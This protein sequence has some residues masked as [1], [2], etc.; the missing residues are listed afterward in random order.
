ME[1]TNS[2][3]SRPLDRNQ[4]IQLG[5]VAAVASIVAV[6]IVQVMA[7]AIWPEIALFKPLD[8][9]LRTAVFTAVPAIIA[10]ALF[11]WL[12]RRRTNPERTFI[13]IAVVVL[14]LSI[15]PDYLLPVEYKTLLASTVTAFL[16]VVAALVIVFVLVSG[17]RRQVG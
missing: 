8:S 4:W 15:I 3:S 17:Y 10:T 11:A 14:L 16:H 6:L 12:S 5:A 2:S 7:I 13:Q 1:I 9:Y